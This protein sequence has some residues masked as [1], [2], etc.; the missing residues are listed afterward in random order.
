MTGVG[1]DG[2]ATVAAGPARSRSLDAGRFMLLVLVVV[3]HTFEQLRPGGADL[4]VRFIYLF[5]MPAFAFISG[6]VSVPVLD[7]R[8]AWRLLC[9]VVAVYL[10][11]QGLMQGLDAL[12]FGHAWQFRLHVPYWLLWYLMSLL[13][14]RL[15]LPF[16]MA[17]RAP[18]VFA[19]ALALIAGAVPG[20][21]YEWS[22]S[23]T[24]AFLPFF[25]AGHVWTARK[26]TQLPTL[27]V[28]ATT[29][30]LAAL[31][32]AAYATRGFAMQ[33]YYNGVGYAGMH[34]GVGAGMGYRLV[35]LVLAAVGVAGFLSLCGRLR[36]RVFALGAASMAPYLM[37]AYLVKLA[38]AFGW[39]A[40]LR[41][42][43]FALQL[44]VVVVPSLA[45][46][47]ACSG[48]GLRFPGL[49][50]FRWLG[51]LSATRDKRN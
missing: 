20:I 40:P 4:A 30:S 31:L 47:L 48:I 10:V 24:F 34:L 3:G 45:V 38:L 17:V 12:L 14:W 49:F 22:L 41:S 42:M 25:V 1:L 7:G 28:W 27:P 39:F 50:D 16:V 35:Y 26:G 51:P 46:V 33:W 37:H 11:H 8:R 21:G 9:S 15:L 43:P 6:M 36:G 29:A 32:C 44:P 13:W 5:H 19:L 18:L 2:R 23:R